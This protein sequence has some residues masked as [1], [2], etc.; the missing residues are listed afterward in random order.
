MPGLAQR[1]A[2]SFD[3]SGGAEYNHVMTRRQLANKDTETLAREALKKAQALHW[4]KTFNGV[5]WHY[6]GGYA[7]VLEIIDAPNGTSKGQP[8]GIQYCFTFHEPGVG[9]EKIG[10]RI[11]G[12]DNSHSPDKDNP[13]DHEHKAV[14]PKEP[15]GAR[16]RE[17]KGQRFTEASI[18]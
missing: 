3:N 6:E 16:P 7:A 13:W 5:V 17:S 2:T 8:E 14:W 15:P 4:L 1:L 11:Y 12:L 10:N 18:E 9:G